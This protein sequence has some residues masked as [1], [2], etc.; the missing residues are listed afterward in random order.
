MFLIG[1]E[2]QAESR[3]DKDMLPALILVF[4]RSLLDILSGSLIK[5]GTDGGCR[6]VSV[7]PDSGGGVFDV[8]QKHYFHHP[9]AN[10][11]R[12]SLRSSILK[13]RLFRVERIPSPDYYNRA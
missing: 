4:P 9:R 3:A 6:E 2:G 8:F 13:K 7:S 11:T 12:N 10:R 1:G 5:D